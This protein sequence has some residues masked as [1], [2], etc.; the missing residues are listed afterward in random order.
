MANT[1][2]RL[3]K[4]AADG[5]EICDIYGNVWRYSASGNSW[6]FSGTLGD[7]AV[8]TESV[9][10][11]ITP[12]IF[13][14]LKYLR[15]QKDGGINF[16]S[17][18]IAPATSALWYYL[19][20][21]NRT[22]RF[23]PESESKLRLEVNKAHLIKLFSQQKCPGPIGKSG[24]KGASGADGKAG[25]KEV[26]HQPTFDATDGTSLIIDADV[27][28]QVGTDISVRL[29]ADGDLVNDAIDIRVPLDSS[30]DLTVMI[31]I[32]FTSI[33]LDLDLTS[34]EYNPTDGRV[35]GVVVATQPWENFSTNWLYKAG[36]IG[37]TGPDGDNG[38]GFLEVIPTTFSDVNLRST[39]AVRSLRQGGARGDIYFLQGELFDKNCVNK[40]SVRQICDTL[41]VTFLAGDE[42]CLLAVKES[43]FE[44][45]DTTRF[46]FS[47]DEPDRPDLVLPD[48]TPVDAC[49][50]QRHWSI[51]RFRWANITAQIPHGMQK[52]PQPNSRIS[53]EP[54]FPFPLLQ[55]QPPGE[56]C[57]VAEGSL[58]HLD[59]GLIPIEKLVVGDKSLQPDGKFYHIEEV[60][61]N[62]LKECVRVSFSDGTDIIATLDHKFNLAGTL[63]EAKDLVIGDQVYNTPGVL[64]HIRK[65]R[66]GSQEDFDR[67][68]IVGCL[69]GDGWITD[70]GIGIVAPDYE[71]ESFEKAYDLLAELFG[72][73]SVS[74]KISDN[75][76]MYMARW[77]SK[78][79][80]A[81]FQDLGWYK[82]NDEYRVEIPNSVYSE[83]YE[84]YRGFMSAL[85][86]TDG[87]ID[88]RGLVNVD[89]SILRGVPH[90]V[91]RILDYLGVDSVLRSH[92]RP[93]NG[94]IATVG[95]CFRTDVLTSATTKLISIL[96]G[97]K[98]DNLREKY[99][100]KGKEK[101]T[102]IIKKNE[103]TDGILTHDVGWLYG[104]YVFLGGYNTITRRAWLST[105]VRDKELDYLE[106]I[107]G[108]RPKR[109]EIN[110]EIEEP[111]PDDFNWALGFLTTAIILKPRLSSEN[112]YIITRNDKEEA[113]LVGMCL[114]VVGINYRE[115]NIDTPYGKTQYQF[116][117]KR[118]HQIYKLFCL[119]GNRELLPNIRKPHAASGVV[120]IILIE[121]V[122]DKHVYDFNCP[123]HFM[124]CVEGKILVDCQDDFFFCS[125]I[126]DELCPVT[127][128]DGGPPE[129]PPPLFP[130][131]CCECDCP[132]ALDLQDGYD[133][134]EIGVTSDQ[135]V[136][137]GGDD[138]F[139]ADDCHDIVCTLE[140]VEHQYRQ[141]ITVWDQ[142]EE[143]TVKTVFR[144][145]FD[146]L[147]DEARQAYFDD[148]VN[149]HIPSFDLNCGDA[150]AEEECPFQFSVRD[151]SK[152]VLHASGLA[153]MVR[154]GP[155]FDIQENGVEITFKHKGFAGSIDFD[156]RVNTTLLN[157]CLA[158][159]L[160][161]CV[162]VTVGPEI[163]SSPSPSPSP[164]APSV[165]P[166]SDLVPS[167]SPSPEGV[168]TI[169]CTTLDV[170]FLIDTT[171]S[172]IDEIDSLKSEIVVILNQIEEKSMGDY[173]LSL[174]TFK[175]V[176]TIE[177]M[178]SLGNRAE[179]EAT[180]P[181][182]IAS[183]G[184]GVA[185][186]SDVAV[187]KSAD[188][189]AGAWRPSGGKL[190]ILMTD[191][192]PGG[193]DDIYTP[194]VDDVAALAAANAA[195]SQGIHIAAVR[196]P[197][198]DDANTTPIMQQYADTT[199]GRHIFSADGTMVGAAVSQLIRDTCV[200][201]VAIV[202]SEFDIVLDI[203]SGF[204]SSQQQI[205]RDAADV[206]E[207]MIV[208]DLPDANVPGE[209]LVDD[210]LIRIE[211][212]S[213]GDG[214]GGLLGFAFIT[215]ERS[216][217][218]LPIRGELHLDVSDVAIL[219]SSGQ[220]MEVVMHEIGHVLGFGVQWSVL[221][222][223]SGAGGSDPRFTGPAALAEYNDIFM[224]S[225]LD[226]PVEATGG[227]GTA[228]VHWR[229]STFDHELLTG[230]LDT[231]FINPVSRIS[232]ASMQDMGYVVNLAAAEDYDP[233]APT[234]SFFVGQQECCNMKYHVP[235][236]IVEV[237]DEA[238]W[239]SEEIN[240]RLKRRS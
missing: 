176:V 158:Y 74:E 45:K 14:Q 93:K 99:D 149:A 204:T 198:D 23:I 165:L 107:L 143:I 208:G 98:C 139:E 90:C 79:A 234:P 85:V 118:S 21:N 207:T 222:L 83:T 240:K 131:T 140:G 40:L 12:E 135:T 89:W 175:D 217:S 30:E 5:A 146:D 13:Q 80:K 51:S 73:N 122:G 134:D 46:C 32:R 212:L 237:T 111:N 37:R 169:D 138:G 105:K 206:W 7:P 238:I 76:V 50:Q 226:V 150:I 185:E 92:A 6:I 33:E 2:P 28:T 114:D 239:A 181:S 26:T 220:L 121:P 213:P 128:P 41:D 63:V 179:F 104:F 75:C 221:G 223:I 57:C 117:I 109:F 8:V 230:F 38:L 129:I 183:G 188:G 218:H 177:V 1:P 182:V 125:N 232:L 17:L 61:D 113:A 186:A 39:E 173:R 191:A 116:V 49:W 190:M 19:R 54:K 211:A 66:P 192:P 52:W 35:V 96:E 132:I 65:T 24:I 216:G 214:P 31:D 103:L 156:I 43:T 34:L 84:F 178:F 147:C 167:V 225:A 112:S 70:N 124:M 133:F 210:L 215:H 81:Y 180:L 151:V 200:D 195:N 229:E 148:L 58:I 53:R 205:F 119:T 62:G 108:R 67:G 25:P 48:W 142:D 71:R 9:D 171:G 164:L 170:A 72:Y 44:C 97:S 110:F 68:Y 166:S 42:L 219:E 77:N 202:T 227:P 154:E 157:C 16:D 102:S 235:I 64:D 201:T 56:R 100:D 10:G 199:N 106:C 209:G 123:P 136:V 91:K 82:S 11:L 115:Q 20:S 47:P 224:T 94:F 174:I 130:P 228:D 152:T 120:S 141:R 22:I 153:P 18:K 168:L 127:G 163:V 172:M 233:A 4:T 189:D 187:Q 161:A 137:I 162:T 69:L 15:Q 36:Q 78:K 29:F 3:P 55:E 203:G 184:I 155:E 193:L 27:V 196:T 145:Q 126:N 95:N 101:Y 194:G 159:F 236:Q 60:F 160:E 231:G 59:R 86:A 87:S 88:K 197:G 144:V